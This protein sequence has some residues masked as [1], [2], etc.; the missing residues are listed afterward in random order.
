MS[1]KSS[2]FRIGAAA[3]LLST[4]AITT[5]NA[6]AHSAELCN[7]V[8]QAFGISQYQSGDTC[9][10]GDKQ[11]TNFTFPVGFT[12]GNFTF[13]EPAIGNHELSFTAVGQQF[14]PGTYAFG[15]TITATQADRII[16]QKIDLSSSVQTTNNGTIA[17]DTLAS[18]GAVTGPSSAPSQSPFFAPVQSLNATTT[19]VVTSGTFTG[20]KNSYLQQS[21]Q[22]TPTPGPL[23]L[24]GAASAFGFSRK[25]RRRIKSQIA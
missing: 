17:L 3:L 5:L 22:G 9:T 12:S 15:Y 11:L 20:W 2:R 1:F 25:L 7:N 10:I 16:A 14:T 4:T 6:P 21:S 13:T 19:V 23:P 24:L 8:F 18:G